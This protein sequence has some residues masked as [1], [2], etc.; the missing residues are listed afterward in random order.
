MAN[1]SSTCLN[2]N[3]L[4]SSEDKL[5]LLSPTG[6]T[7]AEV[8]PSKIRMATRLYGNFSM[9]ESGKIRAAYASEKLDYLLSSIREEGAE[10]LY[11]GVSSVARASAQSAKDSDG[12]RRLKQLAASAIGWNPLLAESEDVFDFSI[13]VSRE[14]GSS[15]FSNVYTSWF[16]ERRLDVPVEA[17]QSVHIGLWEMPVVD[18][19]L[20]F[21]YERNNKRAL[22]HD[23][24]L[25]WSNEDL[26]SVVVK[27]IEG[28]N[29]ALSPVLS[30]VQN[31]CAESNQVKV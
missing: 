28:A 20:E 1:G 2:M 13:R 4:M 16:Q 12:A 30:L 23:K 27:G 18:E 29:R 14:V 25:K 31:K 21:R 10:P 9:P 17:G 22:L 19:G 7:V 6:S 5:V 15:D 8:F 24:R 11:V 26:V 3:Q